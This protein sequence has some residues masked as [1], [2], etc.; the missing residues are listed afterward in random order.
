MAHQEKKARRVLLVLLGQQEYPAFLEPKEFQVLKDHKDHQG[1]QDPKETR[2][3]RDIR[4]YLGCQA[5]PGL[6]E[7]Q[8]KGS[9]LSVST[10]LST[11]LFF[12]RGWLHLIMFCHFR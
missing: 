11:D 9:T 2:A 7:N 6:M 1:K 4:E 5:C 8:V 3:I 12:I 10:T